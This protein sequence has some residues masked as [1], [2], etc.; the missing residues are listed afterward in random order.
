[1]PIKT[2]NRFPCPICTRAL[3]VRLTKKN[4]PYVTCDPC[5]V[6]MFIRGPQG[7]EEFSRLMQRGNNAGLLERLEELERRYRVLCPHCG[8]RFWIERKLVKTSSF[9]GALKGFRCPKCG[10]VAPW[11][12]K[13]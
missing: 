13:P 5:G 9:D 8:S 10:E 4:K 1:M 6:Q 3:D 7:I 12:G 11:E 2:D